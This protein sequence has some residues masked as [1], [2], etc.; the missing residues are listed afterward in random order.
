MG[1][2]EACGVTGHAYE[3]GCL[4]HKQVTIGENATVYS[5]AMVMAGDTIGDG[6]TI[7]CLA[8]TFGTAP[9]PARSM[10]IGVP[11]KQVQCIEI[12]A[13]D[14]AVDAQ[15]SGEDSDSCCIDISFFKSK[16]TKSHLECQYEALNSVVSEADEDDSPV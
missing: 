11:A 14:E 13:D 7:G 16:C 5:G 6:A 1:I 3:H 8:K 4:V 10:V 9:V 2:N 15:L 12:T